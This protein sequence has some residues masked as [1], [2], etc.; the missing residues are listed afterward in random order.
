VLVI[1]PQPFYQERG[2][3]IAVRLL[4]ETLA[5][6]GQAVDLLTYHDGS[7]LDM[8]GVRHIR[9]GRPPG[10]RA[11]PIGISWQ[12]LVADLWLI[13][14][15]IAAVRRN[16][17]DV[18]HAVEEAVFPAVFLNLFLRRK[19]VYDMDS[20]LVD[21][22][23]DK[24]RVLRAVRGLLNAI[25]RATVRRTDLVLAVCEDLAA[26]VRPWVGEG[27][28]VVLPDVPVGD[29]ST[30]GADVEDLRAGLSSG[31]LLALYVGNL[32]RYQGVELLLHGMRAAAH[33]AARV[34]LVV[35]GGARAHVEEHRDTA[36]RLGLGGR[37]HFLGP[38]PLAKLPAYLAQAD[39]LV[40]PRILG[41]NTPMKVYSYMQA[42]KAILATDIRS[43][44]QALDARD[45]ELVPATAAGLGAGLARLAADSAR[46]EH[47]GRAARAK[48]EREYSRQAFEARLTAAYEA[49]APGRLSPA[50]R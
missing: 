34:E 9:A 35:I 45:A 1:A 16:R 8:P 37:V 11:I 18:L 12:K 22:M 17:Y 42:G 28:V 39:V 2:T 43:H 33:E 19:V 48:V 25:E 31:A 13:A 49:L 26:K 40:S 24:W 5:R 21:Q 10:V 30:D 41:Q 38:R 6:N 47:L 44:T 4:V 36:A 46:R 3:P 14:A 20:S 50:A 23:G 27:R 7:D 29:P 32:E 15:M